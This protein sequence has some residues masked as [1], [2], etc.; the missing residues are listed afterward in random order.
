MNIYSVPIVCE[1]VGAGTQQCENRQNSCLGGAD[2]CVGKTGSR[3]WLS[4]A[5]TLKQSKEMKCNG[6][7]GGDPI[8]EK[9]SGISH[10]EVTMEHRLEGS[11][12]GRH[13]GEENS[14]QK[15]QPLQNP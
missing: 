2:I 6:D 4:T 3:D 5:Q 10:Q 11:E 7:L 8:I 13:L 9:G 15:E 12:V 14:R 1:A